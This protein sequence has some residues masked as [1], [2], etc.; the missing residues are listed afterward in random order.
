ME[1][2]FIDRL[3]ACFATQSGV[4]PTCLPGAQNVAD[5][6]ERT[7]QALGQLG[8]LPRR[9]PNLLVH[10]R[11]DC[12]SDKGGEFLVNRELADGQFKGLN[13]PKTA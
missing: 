4:K 8:Q 7:R 10:K 2:R 9:R 1:S 11:S 12:L 13:A 6:P 3:N 5:D